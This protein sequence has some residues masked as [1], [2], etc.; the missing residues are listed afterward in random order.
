VSAWNFLPFKKGD[1]FD[2]DDVVEKLTAAAGK[3]NAEK[4][5]REDLAK[6]DGA[7]AEAEE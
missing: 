7:P 1:E 3:F 2:F 5:T 6:M 4:I